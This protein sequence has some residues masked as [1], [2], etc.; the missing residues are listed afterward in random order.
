MDRIKVTDLFDLSHTMAAELLSGCG[1][2]WEALELIAGFILRTGPALSSNIYDDSGD[3]IWIARDARIAPS[4]V[5]NG[6]CIIGRGAELRPGAYVRGSAIIGGGAV[7]GNSCELKNCILFDG[8]QV[9]HFNYVGD[10]ILGHMAHMGAGA[11]TSNIKGDKTNIVVRGEEEYT[12]GLR[13]LGAMLGDRAEI[14]AGS[15]MNPGAIIGRDSRVYPLSCVRG[16]VPERMIY[17]SRQEIVS[18]E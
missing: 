15:V 1:Y 17:K 2:P 9:P 16:V 3:G 10:S 7:V 14:G 4:A 8:A 5:I 12:T 11:I 18:Q 6:P 13:K